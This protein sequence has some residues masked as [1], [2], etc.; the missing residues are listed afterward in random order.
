MTATIIGGAAAVGLLLGLIVVRREFVA[1]RKSA[2]AQKEPRRTQV[3]RGV[4]MLV[5]GALLF[6][7]GLSKAGLW[8]YANIAVAAATVDISIFFRLDRGTQVERERR[9]L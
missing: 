6:D 3:F 8:G 7:S 9:E 1:R 4:L 5:G 2:T